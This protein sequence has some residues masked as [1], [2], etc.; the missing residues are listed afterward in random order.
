MANLYETT[1]TPAPAVHV[2]KHSSQQQLDLLRTNAP[3]CFDVINGRGQGVQHHLGNTNY[4]M[5]VSSNKGLYAKCAKTDKVKISKG[6]VAA[7]R[8]LGGRFLELDKN[9][10]LFLDIGDKKAW[11][12]T[13][14]SLREGQTRIRE[15]ILGGKGQSKYDISL[16]ESCANHQ[17]GEIPAEGYFGY[18]VQVLQSLYNSDEEIVSSRSSTPETNLKTSPSTSSI[19]PMNQMGNAQSQPTSS[20]EMMTSLDDDVIAIFGRHFMSNCGYNS[21]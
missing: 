7:V 11:E 8:E 16:L 5:L 18:S 9:S 15:E 10:G 6:I 12:K 21:L 2:A 17:S 1:S 20:Q 13:S 19:E 14:Q 4:R 3:T